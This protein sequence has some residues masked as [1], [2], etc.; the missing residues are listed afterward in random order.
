MIESGEFRRSPSCT[1][2]VV[3]SPVQKPVNGNGFYTPAAITVN[4]AGTNYWRA[5]Y[6]GDANN[7]PVPLTGCGDPGESTTVNAGGKLEICKDGANGAAGLPFLF[8]GKSLR[9]G[10]ETTIT[11]VGGTCSSPIDAGVGKWQITE[12]L[13]SGLWSMAGATV[14]P[15]AR[16]V[17]TSTN[18]GYVKIKVRKNAETEVTFINRQAGGAL[19]IC[20]YS[21][22]PALQGSQYSFTVGTTTIVTARAG[23]NQ[24]TAGC[25]GPVGVHPGS[26]VKIKEAVPDSE[27][28]ASA[29]V[30]TNASISS[31]NLSRG[32]VRVIVGPGANAVDIEN[33][34]Q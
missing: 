17:S 12:D 2:E 25:S 1:S 21:S 3:G 9:S 27:K 10:Y 15:G 28:V 29:S 26:I 23:S 14:I 4:T 13:S 24:K 22:S 18:G 6:S 5:S 7:R 34:P 20:K 30:S 33:E 8:T 16:L 31:A 32:V 11:V 19:K